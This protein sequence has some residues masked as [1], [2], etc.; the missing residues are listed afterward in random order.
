MSRLGVMLERMKS[1]FRRNR[2]AN[3]VAEQ[4]LSAL[5]HNRHQSLRLESPIEESTSR[6]FAHET[7]LIDAHDE[8]DTHEIELDSPAAVR[9]SDLESQNDCDKPAG[10]GE[11]AKVQAKTDEVVAAPSGPEPTYRLS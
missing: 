6:S 11:E 3:G 1:L 9:K 10:I 2:H 5:D 7:E 8:D 4:E